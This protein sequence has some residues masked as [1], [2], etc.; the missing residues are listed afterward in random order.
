MDAQEYGDYT[1]K[2]RDL[3]QLYAGFG[4]RP[5]SDGAVWALSLADSTMPLPHIGYQ[6]WITCVADVDCHGEELA[7]WVKGLAGCMATVKPLLGKRRRLLVTKYRQ[8][9]GD[10]AALDGLT[11]ALYGPGS[12]TPVQTRALAFDCDRD[13][14]RRIRDLVAGAV[15]VQLAQFEDALGWAVSVQRRA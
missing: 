5:L 11:L 2:G 12:V 8:D 7:A 3:R 1:I 6:A 10:Q 4:R 13:A 14:Y 9:W 15:L